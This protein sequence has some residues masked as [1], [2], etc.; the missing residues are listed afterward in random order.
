MRVLILTKKKKK[1]LLDKIIDIYRIHWRNI[2]GLVPDSEVTMIGNVCDIAESIG[3]IGG[4]QYVA[5]KVDQM[6]DA[7]MDDLNSELEDE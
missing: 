1:E 7:V 3:G 5:N 6:Y 2:S 4:V